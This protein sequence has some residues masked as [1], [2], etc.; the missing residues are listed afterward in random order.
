M[1]EMATELRLDRTGY[2]LLGSSK[3][4]VDHNDTWQAQEWLSDQGRDRKETWYCVYHDE[5]GTLAR[6]APGL[7]G[8][9]AG[10]SIRQVERLVISGE[11]AAHRQGRCWEIVLAPDLQRLV[12]DYILRG[13]GI[14]LSHHVA[15]AV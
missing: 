13:S 9:V 3:V 8:A 5:D 6:C 4:L 15:V 14:D 7:W 10:C 1:E 12:A 11:L 2:N